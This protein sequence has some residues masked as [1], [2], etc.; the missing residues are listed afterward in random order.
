MLKIFVL[1]HIFV[2][3]VI[4]FF[5]TILLWI[6]SSKEQLLFEI[7]IFCRII[8]IYVVTFNQF[9]AFLLDKRMNWYVCVYRNRCSWR[10]SSCAVNRKTLASWRT[11]WTGASEWFWTFWRVT[12]AAHSCATI[13]ATSALN[14]PFWFASAT[15]TSSYGRGR[16][17]CRGWRRPSPLSPAQ[18]TLTPKRHIVLTPPTCH[19]PPLWPHSDSAHH[20][21]TSLTAEDES[22]STPCTLTS[23]LNEGDYFWLFKVWK[24]ITVVYLH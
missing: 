2:E 19:V 4:H 6:K 13:S 21:M 16:S 10:G 12:W 3:T 17:K 23:A 14:P 20:R 18:R 15:W 7:E 5:F 9:N 22:E 24:S 11:T 1:L 8:N